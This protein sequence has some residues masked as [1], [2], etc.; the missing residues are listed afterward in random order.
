MILHDDLSSSK[1]SLLI[2]IKNT[3]IQGGIQSHPHADH[4]ILRHGTEKKH[5]FDSS[6]LCIIG[7]HG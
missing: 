7:A 2:E 6:L 1:L 5:I 4:Q 3:G